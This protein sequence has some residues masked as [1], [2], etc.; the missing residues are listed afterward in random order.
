MEKIIFAN[1]SVFEIKEGCSIGKVTT[2]LSNFGLLQTLADVLLN[3]DNLKSIAFE[4]N[5]N[6]TGK[7]ENMKLLKPM[8]HSVDFNNG[9]VE[10]TFSLREKTELELEIETIKAEQSIQDEAIAELGSVISD[11]STGEDKTIENEEI[12]KETTEE[13]TI[14]DT[15]E[16][17]V[18]IESEEE[19]VES[20]ENTTETEGDA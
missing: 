10:V 14:T 15:I 20:E 6:V 2:L 5:G 19:L 16:E 3:S 9:Q 7:Y 12:V 11:I 13:T 18:N 8:F 1:N 17:N 4:T